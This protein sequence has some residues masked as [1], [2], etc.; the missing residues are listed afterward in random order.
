MAQRQVNLNHRVTVTQQVSQAQRAKANQ[1]LIAQ[2]RRVNRVQRAIVNQFRTAQRRQVTRVHQ[3]RAD[4]RQV[5]QNRP[6]QRPLNRKVQL[7]VR[8]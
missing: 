6:R 3:V 8:R 1:L 4:R 5:N 7:R 2:K